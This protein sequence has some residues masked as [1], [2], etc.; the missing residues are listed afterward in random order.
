MERVMASDTLDKLRSAVLR[1][2][3]PDR[4]Q[5][6]REL[7]QSLDAPFDADAAGAWDT[8]ILRRLTEID[9]GTAKLVDRD[10]LRRRMRERLA[11]R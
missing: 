3:P 7:V 1:L 8:E 11:T 6:A 2:S 10:E 4:A 9:D 5:L